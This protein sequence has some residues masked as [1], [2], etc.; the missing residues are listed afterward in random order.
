MYILLYH[1]V[2]AINTLEKIQFNSVIGITN[3]GMIRIRKETYLKKK[4]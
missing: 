3:M 2:M 1:D 4:Y